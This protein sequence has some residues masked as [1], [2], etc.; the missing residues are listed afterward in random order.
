[1]RIAA[2]G[3]RCGHV[4]T[5]RDRKNARYREI[6]DVHRSAVVG[7]WWPT[8]SAAR[9]RAVCTQRNS[10]AADQSSENQKRLSCGNSLNWACVWVPCGSRKFNRAESVHLMQKVTGTTMSRENWCRCR[11]WRRCFQTDFTWK[12]Q[13]Y[14]EFLENAFVLR[15]RTGSA[16]GFTSRIIVII[17]IIKLKWTWTTATGILR[18]I[19]DI[20]EKYRSQHY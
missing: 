5:P 14:A 19:G 13:S 16:L 3:T 9:C 4:T 8:H 18:Y 17:I 2:N 7:F 11:A 20:F 1:M 15:G 10:T 12:I 6:G